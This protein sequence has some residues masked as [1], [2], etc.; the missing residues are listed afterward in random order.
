MLNPLRPQTAVVL[1]LVLGLTLLASQPMGGQTFNVIHSFSGV[2]GV[3]PIG[4]LAMDGAG[5]LYG[6]AYGGAA[7]DRVPSSCYDSHM[8]LGW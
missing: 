3:E 7:M 8:A 4:T 2:D 5:R 1:T 6:A